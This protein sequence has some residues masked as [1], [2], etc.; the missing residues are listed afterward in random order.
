MGEASRR[1][2]S[3]PENYDPAWD[4]RARQAAT[5]IAPGSSVLDLGCGPRMSLRNFLPTG[6]RYIPADLYPWTDEVVVCDLDRGEWPDGRF[7]CVTMLGL[8]TY[9]T[10]PALALR[11]ANACTPLLVASFKDTAE[12][13]F[14]R[15]LHE[16]GWEFF[17]KTPLKIGPPNYYLYVARRN[18]RQL[19]GGF[20][21]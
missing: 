1:Y 15:M 7:D 16:S 19:S 5:F 6:C 11:K 8:L 17:I 12:A 9:L 21:K 3:A 4:A 20:T 14:P 10:E 2:W 18:A 13:R